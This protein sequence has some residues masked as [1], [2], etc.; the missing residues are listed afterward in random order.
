[1]SKT[2]APDVDAR[3]DPRYPA[4]A[5]PSIAGVRLTPGGAVELVNISKSGVLVEGRTRLVP[6][7]RLTVVFE[8][9]F[10]PAGNPA[11]VIRCQ[12]ASMVG[13]A[14]RYHSGIQFERRLDV[15]DTVAPGPP[16][17]S[18]EPHS[19]QPPAPT[20]Q[21]SAAKTG[22]RPSQRTGPRRWAVN[23]W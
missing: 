9:A 2:P 18:P 20:P 8:G 12:V 17:P 3:L 16:P 4:S 1:M 7:T 15:L 10:T 13:G 11:K 22:S 14:L 23:R 21:T 19:V 5:V 6:G